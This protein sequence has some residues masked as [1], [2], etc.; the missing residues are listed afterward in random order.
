[1]AP[2]EGPCNRGD[3]VVCPVEDQ[4]LDPFYYY[5]HTQQGEGG[6]YTGSAFVPSGIWPSEYK[7]MFIDF[8]FHKIYN[9]VED[10]DREKRNISPPIPGYRNETFHAHPFMV[11]MF[12]GPYKGGQA[13]YYVARSDGQNVR[14]I[15]YTGSINK[16]PVASL[17]VSATEVG[18]GEF[19]SFTGSDS[20][21]AEGDDL[22]YLWDFGDGDTSTAKN[23]DHA[24]QQK[25]EYTVTLTV[26]DE[27]GQTNQQ[28]V[29]LNV[30]NRPTAKMI[31]PAEGDEFFVGQ[32][33][34]LQ[35][36]GIDAGGNILDSSQ[37]SWEVRQHHAE[38]FH[39]FLDK[40][41]GNK[42]PLFPAPEPEDFNAATN[43]YLFGV[44]HVRRRQ[45][46]FGNDHLPTSESKN[47]HG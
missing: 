33:I 11:D 46:W 36:S 24:F 47:C 2:K 8:V 19:V 44:H 42:F 43:S 5:E 16:A 32:V 17:E 28:Y 29:E 26:T 14:R 4:Y 23:P 20:S 25:G 45:G 40:T 3:N 9:L 12:F 35:G 38:H 31:S 34:Q 39:P 18:V 27:S 7:Y 21:D 10:P 37:L 13:L 41:A 22:D 1:M 15:R 30:G 6:A